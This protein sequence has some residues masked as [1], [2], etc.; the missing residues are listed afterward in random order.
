M[1]ETHPSK[2]MLKA[3]FDSNMDEKLL[4]K[5]NLSQIIEEHGIEDYK[6]AI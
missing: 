5:Y 2:E 1:T 4:S 6:E 3:I